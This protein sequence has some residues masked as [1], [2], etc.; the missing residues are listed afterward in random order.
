L[1]THDIEE[2]VYLSQRIIVM[3]KRP[4]KVLADIPVTLAFPRDRVSEE[5]IEVR[6]QVMML[7][8]ESNTKF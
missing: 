6:K 1:V 5:F 2:A 3:S 7:L 4:A 8:G